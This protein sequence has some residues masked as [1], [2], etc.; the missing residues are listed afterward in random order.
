MRTSRIS[1]IVALGLAAFSFSGALAVFRVLDGDVWARLAVGRLGAVPRADTWAF[2]PTLPVWTDHEWGAGVV[3]YRLYDWFGWPGLMVFKILTGLTAVGLAL[4]VARRRGADWPGLLLLAIP[5]ALA[6]LPG[7]VPT[8]RS[9]AFTFVFFALTVWCLPR[10]PAWIPLLMVLWVNVHGGF[11]VGLIAVAVLAWRRPIILLAALGA[12]LVNP[13]GPAFWQYLVP[14]ILHPRTQIAEWGRL[15]LT[16]TGPYAGFWILLPVVLGLAWRARQDREGL[17]LLALT[18][19]AAWLHRRHLPF[20]GLTA[21]MVLGPHVPRVGMAWGLG[22]QAVV[23]VV[24]AGW[25]W[26]RASLMPVAPRTFYPVE[27]VNYLERTGAT[28]HLAVPFR[29]G[30]YASW[31]L[32]PRMKVSMDGRYETVYPDST[33]EMNHD[34]FYRQGPQWDRLVRRHRVDYILVE[35]KTTHLTPADLAERGYRLVWSDATAALWA[36]TST[37]PPGS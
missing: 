24:V 10:H 4:A 16:L 17:V 20:F 23:A 21:L 26:P 25:L 12:T 13:Y 32:F 27:A 11:V 1:L 37:L 8:V 15:P 30:S 18:A 35:R 29:W 5:A 22:A 2:T 14:A 9:H 6:V 31:R 34:F 19:L 33:F 3:F 36:A 28:G 7:Y